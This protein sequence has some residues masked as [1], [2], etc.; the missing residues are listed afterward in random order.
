M[1]VKS[2]SGKVF[3]IPSAEET[4][5]IKAAINS[6]ADTYELSDDKM[7]KLRPIGRPKQDIT[8][9]SVSIRLSP[10]VVS[11]FK[12]TGKGWQTRIDDILKAYVNSH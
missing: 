1:Q 7:K 2:K 5:Q 4:A 6:D 10:E 11:Y 9:Q 8:K 12:A 3:D